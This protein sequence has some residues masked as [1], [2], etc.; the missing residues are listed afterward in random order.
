MLLKQWMTINLLASAFVLFFLVPIHAA[1][2][3]GPYLIFDGVNTEMRVLWQL[4][5]SQSCSIQ[6]GNDLLYSMGSAAT[7]E[8]GSDIY[9]HQHTYT[10][11][12]LTPGTKYFYRVNCGPENVGNGSFY[13]APLDNA[14]NVKFMVYGDSRLYPYYHNLVNAQMINTYTSRD[15]AYQSITLHVGDWVTEGSNEAHWASEVFNRASAETIEFQ[16]N[17]PINSCIGDHEGTGDLFVKYFP[18]LYKSGDFY[19]SFDYGPV[20]ISIINSF[21]DYSPGSPQYTWLQNDLASSTK[22]WKVLLLHS[23]GWSAGDIHMN[24]VDVQNYIQPLAVQYGVDILFAGDNHYY[25]RATVN[26]IQ[27]VTTGGGGA[28]LYTPDPT[29]EYVVASASSHHFCEIEIN[30]NNLYFKARDKD[31]EELDSFHVNKQASFPWLLF[32]LTLQ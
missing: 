24:N 1:V 18:Y 17:N 13:T 30:G 29:R 6:W 2:Q 16:A 19:W 22:K 14:D 10:V 5:S 26:G 8:K 3:K 28:P 27:H 9:G 11:T 23:P 7:V 25:A 31:G 20:H 12:G 15:S 32:L 4:D 21:I